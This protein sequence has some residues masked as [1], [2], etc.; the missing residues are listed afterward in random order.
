VTRRSTAW[1]TPAQE[2]LLRAALS[3]GDAAVESW[4]AWCRIDEIERTDPDSQRLLPLVYR[5]LVEAGVNDAALGKL[6]G[7]YRYWWYRNQVLFHGGARALQALTDAGLDTMILKSTAL[8]T[9]YYGARGAR[10]MRDFDVLV[11]TEDA[12]TATRVLREHG[13]APATPQP[14][15]RLDVGHAGSFVEPGGLRIDLHSHLLWQLDESNDAWAAARETSLNG[16]PTRALCDTDQLLSVCVDGARWAPVEP[17]CWVADAVKV[18]DGAGPALDWDRLIRSARLTGVTVSSEAALG[19]LR[20]AFGSPVP[21]EVVTA[22]A[23]SR[24]SRVERLEFGPWGRPSRVGTLLMLWDR[25]RRLARVRAPGAS[26]PGFATFLQQHYGLERRSQI[27][28]YG[29]RKFVGP[30]R[31]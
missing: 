30:G 25:H 13:W 5:S 18:I 2:L 9:L 3:H 10:P 15:L 11:R 12:L 7:A 21:A 14:Q 8:A 24:R 16:V 20:R 17:I 29:L 31:R 6:R 4:R 22:L 28:L 23:R 1:P 19:Y 26:T 27:P